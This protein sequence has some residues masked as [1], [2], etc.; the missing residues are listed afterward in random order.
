MPSPILLVPVNAKTDELEDEFRADL[1]R[2]GPRGKR[3]AVILDDFK[4]GS[5]WK[6]VRFG[7]WS[8]GVDGFMLVMI[9]CRIDK[10][11]RSLGR[12]HGFPRGY[13]IIWQPGR[14]L[15]L[16]GFYP[17][18]A[19]DENTTSIL[20]SSKIG[21]T[22]DTTGMASAPSS[23][24]GPSPPTPSPSK[25]SA[26]PHEK[27]PNSKI[28]G[29]T[30]N[31]DEEKT[32]SIASKSLVPAEEPSLL[33]EDTTKN[34]ELEEQEED[35]EEEED[36]R[37]QSTSIPSPGMDTKN[38]TPIP[39]DMKKRGTGPL[40]GERELIMLSITTKWSG[41][42]FSM[43]AFE[44]EGAYYWFVT[45]KNS[46]DCGNE[47]KN[48]MGDFTSY[49][50]EVIANTL[51]PTQLEATVQYLADN[52]LYVCGELLCKYD[53][54]HGYAYKKEA[55]V[56]TCAGHYDNQFQVPQDSSDT[57]L[58]L[59]SLE[60]MQDVA[61]TCG[62]RY[63]KHVDVSGQNLHPFVRELEKERD[64]LT[65]SSGIRVFQKFGVPTE[66]LEDHAEVID[67][68][69]LEG[70]IL[71]LHYSDGTK[72]RMKWKLPHYTMV[73]MF[74]R[75]LLGKNEMRPSWAHI[76]ERAADTANRWCI[77]QEGKEYYTQF[78]IVCASEMFKAV[79]E[80]AAGPC[81]LDP[82][83][84]SV[85]SSSS[86]ANIPSSTGAKSDLKNEDDGKKTANNK[87]VCKDSVEV[88]VWIKIAE[89]VAAMD[90]AEVRAC[91]ANLIGKRVTSTN[92]ELPKTSTSKNP[93]NRKK[94][95]KKH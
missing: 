91:A 61:R 69:I 44:H 74:L 4:S 90:R 55:A 49:A 13:P 3:L 77:T 12:R 53:Q 63:V 36:R 75:T 40:S 73:T 5:K 16:L 66:Q 20:S 28:V 29:E 33:E 32:P 81:V 47:G 80:T 88:S 62:F 85:A 65:C 87:D 56:V 27:Q 24:S 51:G 6:P 43:A 23:P 31:D 37:E 79:R 93:K 92:S 17:K 35:E 2:S 52:Q 38:T 58:Q 68:D 71:L 39:A 1:A 41:F 21:Y 7:I 8:L 14:R 48:N 60:D 78:G 54:R 94:W 42:L 70:F 25:S 89:K 34:D 46:G 50:R 72:E 15:H 10:I 67:S 86:K 26:V 64:F 22:P 9:T 76:H 11:L 45:S 19:N 95:R 30:E 59:L 82:D 18:F 83:N 57:L 84:I